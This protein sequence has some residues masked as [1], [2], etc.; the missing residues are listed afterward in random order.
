MRQLSLFLGL[1]LAATAQ[2]QE[3]KIKGIAQAATPTEIKGG[4]GQ[5]LTIE[6]S[7]TEK[8]PI[9]WQF[10]DAGLSQVDPTLLVRKDALVVFGLHKGVY[11]VIAYHRETRSAPVTLFVVIGDAPSPTPTP[12]PT[13]DP[14]P[15]P[16]PVDALTKALREAWAKEAEGDKGKLPTLVDIYRTAAKTAQDTRYKTFKDLNDVIKGSREQ[17]IGAAL[18]NLRGV[19]NAELQRTLPSAVTT[20]MDDAGRKLCTET[21][22]KIAASLAAVV[23][24]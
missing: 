24:G 15:V 13:P 10:L 21:F 23:G 1:L 12:T 4:I 7:S 14:D 2:S 5:V 3:I 9:V 19:V 8:H 22:N 17:L 11:R 6:A 18:P 16:V 20:A